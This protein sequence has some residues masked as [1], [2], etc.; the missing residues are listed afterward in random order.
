M[1]YCPACNALC[2]Y[3]STHCD[4]CG[5][6]LFDKVVKKIPC[7][8]CGTLN[9]ETAAYCSKC[10][11]ALHSAVDSKKTCPKC[12]RLNPA[13]A[14]FCNYCGFNM[15]P[16]A[17]KS[18][19]SAVVQKHKLSESS[20]SND[21]KLKS[22]KKEKNLSKEA[23]VR[24]IGIAA[25][26]VILLILCIGIGVSSSK[27]KYNFVD[28]KLTE[29]VEVLEKKEKEYKVYYIPTDTYDING[30]PVV[31]YFQAVKDG[32]TEKDKYNKKAELI[33]LFCFA[34]YVEI[35]TIEKYGDETSGTKLVLTLKNNNPNNVM[36]S[37]VEFNVSTV[38][39][40]GEQVTPAVKTTSVVYCDV[41]NTAQILA[42]YQSGGTVAKISDMVLLFSDGSKQILTNSMTSKIADMGTNIDAIPVLV[43]NPEGETEISTANNMDGDSCVAGTASFIGI[44]KTKSGSGLNHRT[45]SNTSSN[46][47]ATIPNDTKLA[48]D[49]IENGFGHCTYNGIEGWVS[50]DYVECFYIA[51]AAVNVFAEANNTSAAV[52]SLA[53]GTVV[54]FKYVSGNYANIG[55]GFVEI[56]LLTSKY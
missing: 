30:I 4:E 20:I 49:K 44:V 31:S 29:A 51:N 55:N 13:D 37:N 17:P 56:A 47:L 36:L 14:M 2:S 12:K 21:P 5:A 26:V 50:L 52:G 1:R 35:T 34:P 16:T 40:K 19:R 28:K 23:L 39:E 9:D 33:E 6:Q 42:D 46:F 3:N 7:E 11:T 43:T 32:V 24:L 22:I 53:A 54:Y 45:G 18:P 41:G 15:S 38:D 25:A 8:T 27:K 48:F 10:R